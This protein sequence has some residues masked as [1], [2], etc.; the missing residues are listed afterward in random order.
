MIDGKYRVEGVLGRGGM[1]IVLK[2][3]HLRLDEP[4]AIKVL[5]ASL[6]NDPDMAARMLREARS[7]LRLSSEHIVRVMDVDTL[8]DGVPYMVLEY[9]EGTD[10]ATLLRQR[11]A[12]LGPEETVAIALQACRALVEASS[13]GIVHRDLKPANLFIVTRPDGRRV[14]KL[15]DFGVAKS[16]TGNDAPITRKGDI[17]GSPRYM[18]PEQIRGEALDGRADIWSMGVVLYEMLSG[19]SPFE[20]NNFARTCNRVLREKHEPLAALCPDLPP[21]L[22]AVVE[23]C[24]EKDRERRYPDAGALREA[25]LPFE[26][27]AMSSSSPVSPPHAAQEG[28]PSAPGDVRSGAQGAPSSRAGAPTGSFALAADLEEGPTT[29]FR[30]RSRVFLWVAVAGLVVGIA[31]G[32]ALLT[33]DG[34]PSGPAA[35][36]TSAT[37]LSVAAKGPPHAP[38]GPTASAAAAPSGSVA[39]S[40]PSSSAAGESEPSLDSPVPPSKRP[41]G[42]PTA[43]AGTRP[44]PAATDPFGERRR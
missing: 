17:I 34:T 41:P 20:T 44:P 27:S 6:A 18:A 33:R 24:L 23:R 37:S 9:L 43:P 35:P 4:V 25:L 12:R 19:A 32:I 36:G 42:G 11:G 2:A 22:A 28:A 8:E 29:L 38:P 15:L 1:G 26:S 16:S 5:H 10:V 14:V 40:Q 39:A 3:R 30:R 21:G 13:I 31:A 7:T